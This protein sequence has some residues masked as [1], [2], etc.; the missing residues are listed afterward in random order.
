MS[1]KL[2]DLR[3]SVEN[4]NYYLMR[5]EE[6]TT[7]LGVPISSTAREL[8]FYGSWGTWKAVDS[9]NLAP[10]KVRQKL[11]KLLEDYLSSR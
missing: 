7:F 9:D 1:Y 4:P 2:L 10:E 3:R 5:V 11:E 6:R 8:E